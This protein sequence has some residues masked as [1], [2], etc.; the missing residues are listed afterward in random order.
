[1]LD[2]Y[3]C[4]FTF[5]IIIYYTHTNII[6]ILSLL[7]YSAENRHKYRYSG[8]GLKGRDDIRLEKIMIR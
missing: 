7:I 5:F 3:L 8:N 4:L 6:A 1:M 2:A